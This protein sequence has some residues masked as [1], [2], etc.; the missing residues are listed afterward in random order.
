MLK[1]KMTKTKVIQNPKIEG[2]YNNKNNNRNKRKKYS[3]ARCQELFKECLR[4]L[5]DVVVNN[6]RACLEL[7]RQPPEESEVRTLY[8]DLWDRA[9]PTNPPIP[10]SRASELVINELFPSTTAEDVSEKLNKIR[11]KAGAGPDGF[12]K[13]HLIISGLPAILAKIYNISIYSSYF[14]TV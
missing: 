5:A 2:N 14:P 11:K 12:Q 7:T 6:D 8:E 9:G 13:E 10:G 4:K 1:L 3:Y